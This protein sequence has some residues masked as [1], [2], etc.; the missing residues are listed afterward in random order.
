MKKKIILQSSD[1]GENS[2]H[3]S[4]SRQF[5]KFEWGLDNSPVLNS[6][7]VL[8]LCKTVLALNRYML[9]YLHW[10][11]TTFAICY[12]MVLIKSIM[13]YMYLR[14]KEEMGNVAQS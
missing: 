8:W 9:K 5:E 7:N 11:V 12:E 2:L 14:E 1:C 4:Y 6:I 13:I 10:M 3:R